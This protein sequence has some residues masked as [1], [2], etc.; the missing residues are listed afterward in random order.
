[1]YI[2]RRNTKGLHL[3]PGFDFSQDHR[4]VLAAGEDDG[5]LGVEVY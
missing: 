4:A 1:M 5:F 3:H 2:T